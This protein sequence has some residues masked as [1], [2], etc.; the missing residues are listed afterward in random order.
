MTKEAKSMTSFNPK[1][2][3]NLHDRF[4]GKKES[5][6]VLEEKAR[7]RKDQQRKKT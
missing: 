5:S 3:T 6:N 1:L 2:L 7:K 4:E